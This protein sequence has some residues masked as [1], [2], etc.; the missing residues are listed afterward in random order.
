M[1]AVAGFGCHNLVREQLVA[2][3]PAQLDAQGWD[4]QK[5]G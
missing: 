3:L 1:S 5:V 2:A 4:M